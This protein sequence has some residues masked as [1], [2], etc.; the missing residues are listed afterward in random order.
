MTGNDEAGVTPDRASSSD[1]DGGDA[2]SSP[3][4][5]ASVAAAAL[6]ALALA[7]VAWRL[8]PSSLRALAGAHAWGLLAT[9]AGLQLLTLPMKAAGWRVALDAVHA[10]AVTFRTVL[11]PV[12]VGALFNLV[13]AGRV[14]DAARVLLVHRRL[15][16]VHSSTPISLVVGSAITET[17]VSTMAWV[18]LIAL[19]GTLVPLPPAAWLAIGGVGLATVAAATAAWRGWGRRPAGSANRPLGRLTEALWR[20]WSVVAEGHRALRRRAVMLPL[21]AA[22]LTGWAAQWGTIY[23]VLTAFHVDDAWRTATLVLV[24]TSI[25]QTLPVVPGN[26]GVFQAAAGL[27]LVA[28]AGV[29]VTTSLAI[30]I[31]LQFVQVAPIAIAGALATARQGEEL[32]ELWRAARRFRPRTAEPAR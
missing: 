31:V 3:G 12:A 4:P 9:A 21:A 7:I 13:L 17:L 25:A 19:A 8:D 18:V 10:G 11:G 15:V 27:P 20:V 6:G 16:R 23:A 2:P 5:A 24:S 32:G 29:P 26:V 22:A 14:G 1:P 30:G 28:A